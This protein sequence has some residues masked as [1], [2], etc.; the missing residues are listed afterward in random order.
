MNHGTGNYLVRM[1]RLVKQFSSLYR[2]VMSPIRSILSEAIS[3]E[4]D[5]E[6]SRE[7]ATIEGI[8]NVISNLTIGRMM[9]RCP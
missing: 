4:A 1:A 3:P 8:R 9:R 7:H 6:K 2:Q 5:I